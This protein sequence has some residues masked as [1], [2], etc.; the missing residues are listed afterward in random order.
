VRHRG[1]QAR[2][3]GADR[4]PRRPPARRSASPAAAAA[5]SPTSTPAPANF[6]SQNPQFCIS[7]LRRYTQRDFIALVE[8]YGIAYHE[9]T[10]GQLFCDGS[11]KQIIEML[12]TEMQ[13]NGRR[14]CGCRPSRRGR[15]QGP[16]K[17][18]AWLLPTGRLTCK[19]LVVACGGKSIPKMGATGLGYEIAQQFGLPWS[20]PGRRWCR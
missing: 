19:S 12:L 8:R 16:A 18:G 10:L 6:L 20:R 1:G 13:D 11:A 9:K 14:R 15:R 5:T 4:R 3:L 17:G 2:P 7:A